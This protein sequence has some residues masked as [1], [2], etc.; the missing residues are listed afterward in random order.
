MAKLKVGVIGCGAIAQIQHL[1]HPREL[2]DDFAI[3]GLSDLS[4]R[5]RGCCWLNRRRGGGPVQV[6]DLIDW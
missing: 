2:G 4:P 5:R 1:P 6:A 3:G